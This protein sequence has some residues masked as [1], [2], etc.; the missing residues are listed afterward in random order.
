M[1]CAGMGEE[2][3]E[4]GF[5]DVTLEDWRN[6]QIGITDKVVAGS[7]LNNLLKA[8][9]ILFSHS[10]QLKSTLSGGIECWS[11]LCE[12]ILIMLS[13]LCSIKQLLRRIFLL[14]LRSLTQQQ[15]SVSTLR[16]RNHHIEIKELAFGALEFIQIWFQHFS[17]FISY[18][19]LLEMSLLME[20]YVDYLQIIGFTREMNLKH[21]GIS[22]QGIEKLYQLYSL[23]K[24]QALTSHHATKPLK[25]Q[26][27]FLKGKWICEEGVDNHSKLIST[28]KPF[29]KDEKKNKLKLDKQTVAAA[30]SSSK[31]QQPVINV[32]GIRANLLDDDDEDGGNGGHDDWDQPP[33]PIL[34]T[35]HLQPSSLEHDQT[36]EQDEDPHRFYPLPRIPIG[37]S[38]LHDTLKQDDLFSFD[39]LE[40]ARQW[41]LIDHESYVSISLAAYYNCEWSLPRHQQT[42]LT[43]PIRSFIDR[44]NAQ[45][46]WI[47]ESLITTQSLEKRVKLYGKYLELAGHLEALNNFNG[48]MAILTA[49]Q[50][51]CVTRLKTMM[52]HVGDKAMK[53]LQKFQVFLLLD[54]SIS[55]LLS[56]RL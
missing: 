53:Q 56:L 55:P 51:G 17:S 41:T 54:L 9:F 45:S 40:I 10:K 19:H 33:P 18:S 28:V 36:A 38:L 5:L 35:S 32:F 21:G 48:V 34:L 12:T 25:I 31:Q 7:T 4:F 2:I 37:I 26:Q 24:S 50:Q 8:Q 13:S 39:L 14:F 3:D 30:G 1:M 46:C 44:F 49:L 15:K 16:D 43:L 52:E 23:I 22:S 20:E 42:Y 29:N 27:E 11:E 47:T 6:L